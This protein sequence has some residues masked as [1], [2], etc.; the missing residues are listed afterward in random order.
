MIKLHDV[1]ITAV[2]YRRHIQTNASSTSIAMIPLITKVC[3]FFRESL[4]SPDFN[5]IMILFNASEPHSLLHIGPCFQSNASENHDKM[6]PFITKIHFFFNNTFIPWLQSDNNPFK[7]QFGPFSPK[8]Y[9]TYIHLY[10]YF[11][12]FCVHVCK[13]HETFELIN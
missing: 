12:L 2:N 9:T 1:Y 8:I 13:V 10:Q 3:L 11:K 7:W 4:L 5:L 6:I